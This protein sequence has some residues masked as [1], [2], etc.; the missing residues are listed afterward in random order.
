[1]EIERQNRDL[2]SAMNDRTRLQLR[3]QQTVEGLSV[4]AI[5]YYI[6]GLASYVLKGLKDVG[7][8]PVDVGLATAAVVPLALLA[9]WTVVRRIRRTEDS[10]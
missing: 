5:T 9:V 1:V 6:V 10:A 2:L 8:L 7:W 4:A 3:L